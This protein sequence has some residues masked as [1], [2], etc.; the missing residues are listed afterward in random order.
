MPETNAG[1]AVAGN[2]PEQPFFRALLTPYRSLGR[3][4]FWLLIGALLFAWVV[5]G[6]FFLSVGAW[7]I[8]GFFGLDVV[9][10][11]IAYHWRRGL[12]APPPVPERG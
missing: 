7:P 3:T 1:T 6:I 9:G 2:D 11:Y 8:F 12:P 4:G 10:V 5:T